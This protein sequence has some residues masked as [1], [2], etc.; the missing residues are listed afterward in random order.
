MKTDFCRFNMKYNAEA[1][2]C[3]CTGFTLFCEDQGK[4][5]PKDH[6]CSIKECNSR[7]GSVNKCVPTTYKME[8]CVSRGTTK[9]CSAVDE[10]RKTRYTLTDIQQRF[11]EDITVLARLFEDSFADIEI[12]QGNKTSVLEKVKAN[13]T[14]SLGDLSVRFLEARDF[15]GICKAR[16]D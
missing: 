16:S 14:A 15:G 2:R 10:E 5:I 4:C 13:T 3:E 9:V 7:G 12:A 8:I 1:K 6:C 11:S